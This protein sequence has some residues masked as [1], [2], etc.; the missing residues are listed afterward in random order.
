MIYEFFENC[1]NRNKLLGKPVYQVT[2]VNLK[3][4]ICTLMCCN[5]Y[6]NMSITVVIQQ[7]VQGLYCLSNPSSFVNYNFTVFDDIES[8]RIRNMMLSDNTLL[9]HGSDG[10]IVGNLKINKNKSVSDFGNGFYTGENLLQAENRASN[11]SNGMVYAYHYSLNGVN[12]YSF[13]DVVLWSIYVGYNRKQLDMQRDTPPKLATILYNIDAFDVIVGIIADDKISR[14]YDLFVDNDI[15]D[16]CLVEC[17][18]LVKYGR[19]FVFKTTR[20]LNCLTEVSSYKLTKEMK[21]ASIEWNRKLK[22]DIDYA[23]ESFRKKYRRDGLFLEE[24]LER[25]AK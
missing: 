5:N 15:T 1:N 13:D 25:Y 16:K 21:K 2:F 7:V 6:T 10:G 12:V 18:K 20:S 23:V 24:A 9:F 14:V 22:G 17:L 3:H 19:Q 8:N 11:S 4:D